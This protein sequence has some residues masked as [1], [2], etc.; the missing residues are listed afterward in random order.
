MPH[1]PRAVSPVAFDECSL[2]PPHT[3]SDP[4]ELLG[5]DD[6]LN[7]LSRAA[8]RRRI[9]RLAESYLRGQPLFIASAS[10]RG[11]FDEGWKNP[12]RKERR[13]KTSG[14]SLSG[15]K[16]LEDTGRKT[17][18]P[19]CVQETDLKHVKHKSNLT[20][21]SRATASPH[22]AARETVSPEIFRSVQRAQPDFVHPGS[23]FRDSPRLPKTYTEASGA[24][25]DHTFLGVGSVDWLKKDRRSKRM[26]YK[27]FEPPTSPTPH[28]GSR[29]SAKK[30][31]R[32]NESNCEAPVSSH[33]SPSHLTPQKSIPV[34]RKSP[35]STKKHR[36]PAARS[37]L[38]SPQ[39]S[40]GGEVS[41]PAK[42][43][44]SPKRHE[45]GTSFRVVSSTSQ[46]AR[47]EYRQLRMPR[48]SPQVSL[49]SPMMED[50]TAEPAPSPSQESNDG[51]AEAPQD[52]EKEDVEEP[53]QVELDIIPNNDLMEVDEDIQEHDPPDPPVDPPVQ[54][55]KSIRFADDTDGGNST[56]KSVPPPTEQNTYEEFPSAQLVPVPPGISDR[57][58]SL[59]STVVPQQPSRTEATSTS[60]TQLSTQAALLLAQKSFQDDLESPMQQYGTTP[61]HQRE[62]DPADES[63]LALE[64]PLFRPGT[65]ER[66]PRRSFGQSEKGQMHAMSTQ[67]MLDAATP[68]TFS[69]GKKPRAFRSISPQ[70]T[71]PIKPRALHVAENVSS[72]PDPTLRSQN[73]SPNPN[74]SPGGHVDTHNRSTTET[75]SLPLALSGS[76]PTAS[77]D[78][79]VGLW[80]DS[81]NLNQAIA[82]AGTWLQQSFDFMKDV[83]RSSQKGQVS[84]E[85]APSASQL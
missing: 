16:E 38:K 30:R 48:S 11:P 53:D 41:S 66:A 3:D 65:P 61:G 69:T 43:I 54:L 80:A 55:S 42:V 64:T 17:P 49:D 75:T 85:T 45:R 78:G 9:E 8:K 50:I 74:H 73:G 19:A 39:P 58:P 72:S 76:T 27:A 24:E 33:A 21:V 18:T 28:S 34:T 68:F 22:L 7:S 84:S 26:N 57:V 4:D 35:V 62:I 44:D 59:H 12:W 29:R 32:D 82:D 83:G 15:A 25:D 2:L 10:L 37:P 31:S 47:F 71:N 1:H 6:E 36:S 81:L 51:V 52:E 46:L 40:V 56:N 23:G 14:D 77:Q 60:D 5:S 67:C 63:L 20:L 13:V 79:Q 70:N